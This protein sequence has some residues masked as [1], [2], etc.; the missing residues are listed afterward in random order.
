MPWCTI[1]LELHNNLVNFFQGLLVAGNEEQKAQYL[2]RLASGEMLAAF[3]LTEPA[4]GS[5]AGS[6]R[7]RAGMTLNIIC[8]I[9]KW[10][11]PLC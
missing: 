5:D 8:L 6:I 3:A 10:L 1:I 4:S 11:F 7:T 9:T 2:P